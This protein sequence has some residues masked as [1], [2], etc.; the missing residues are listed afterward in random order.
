MR[1]I[2]TN[3]PAGEKLSLFTKLGYGMGDLYGGG[4]MTITGSTACIFSPASSAS[5]R[6]SREWL[7]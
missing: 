7:L 4:A 5:A 3:K 6:C 2:V 1:T